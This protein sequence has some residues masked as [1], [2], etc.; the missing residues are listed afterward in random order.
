M[1]PKRTRIF[2][3][4]TIS[5]Y[6]RELSI[7]IIG[8]L[9]TLLITN[10]ISSYNRQKE[11]KGILGFIKTELAENIEDL[12]WVQY[13]WEGE[14]QF[15][16]LL[17]ENTEDPTRIPADTLSKYSYAIGTLYSLSIKDE[18]YELLKSSMLMQYVKE[19]DLL[20]KLSKTYGSLENL[21]QQLSSYTT[22]KMSIFLNPLFA[23]MSEKEIKNGT[24]GDV[25]AFSNYVVQK[26]EFRK[27]AFTSQTILS[28]P[29]IFDD[30]KKEIQEIIQ[31]LEDKG[32]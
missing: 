30:C 20:R 17:L 14:Q 9:I 23:K 10:G 11:I 25:Y 31:A 1:K 19:K 2:S 5:E 21:N 26:E 3:N 15:F 4:T 6:L 29:S 32:F 22:Q 18:S 16:R 13:R 8:V 28:P 27:F 7:V 12:E 24:G